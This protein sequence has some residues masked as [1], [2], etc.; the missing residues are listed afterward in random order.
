ML[1]TN[2]IRYM[3]RVTLKI[4]LGVHLYKTWKGYVIAK[5]KY[6]VDRMDYYASVIRKLQEELGLPIS[7]FPKLGLVPEGYGDV[8]SWIY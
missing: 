2:R 8:R 6:E 5:N 4:K 1:N 3:I 7:F